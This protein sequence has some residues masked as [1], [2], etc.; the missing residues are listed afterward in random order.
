MGSNGACAID[1]GNKL[2]SYKHTSCSVPYSTAV[3]CS[4]PSGLCSSHVDIRTNG[5][6]INEDI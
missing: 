6:L 4:V 3:I 5:D 1:S 2:Y